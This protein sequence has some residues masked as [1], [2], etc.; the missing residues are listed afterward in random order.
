MT[1]SEP[2]TGQTGGD[3]SNPLTDQEERRPRE[4]ETKKER[5]QDRKRPREKETKRK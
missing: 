5:D 3:G 2:Q 4:K 1:N